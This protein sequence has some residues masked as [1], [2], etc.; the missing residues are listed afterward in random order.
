[1]EVSESRRRYLKL[2]L[3]GSLT[4]LAGCSGNGTTDSADVSGDSDGGS[5]TTPASTETTEGPTERADQ[6]DDGLA[7][8]QVVSAV[9][10]DI[11][12]SAVRTVKVTV[13]PAPSADTVDLSRVVVQ[14]VDE[15][16]VYDPSDG[17]GFTV[18]PLK[19][20]NDSLSGDIPIVDDA[21]DRANLVFDV[22]SFRGDGNP[23][24]EW[25]SVT[26]ELTTASG[27]T[28]TERLTLPESLGNKD[29]V[30]L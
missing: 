5:Q 18:S 9:G 3:A 15:S 24:S 19:D 29:A 21:G 2:L 22:T 13:R 17:D 11:E 16:G 26:V 6:M 1:M 28:T 20:E 12:N 23:L 30:V 7:R 25:S 8:L 14:W 4:A 10:T 27:G